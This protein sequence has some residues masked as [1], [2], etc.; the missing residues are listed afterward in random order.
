MEF[1][2]FTLVP[3]TV[4]F[5]N[6]DEMK[7]EWTNW[8]TTAE[9]VLN[10]TLSTANAIQ[11]KR[12]K[13]AIHLNTPAFY[14]KVDNRSG[15][16]LSGYMVDVH[17][18]LMKKGG[19]T[20]EYILVPNIPNGESWTTRLLEIL[21]YVDLYANNWYSDTM[22]RR[23][24]GIALTQPIV[25]ASL[26]LITVTEVGIIK[27]MPDGFLG[28][29]SHEVWLLLLALMIYHSCLYHVFHLDDSVHKAQFPYW[30][31]LY[32]SFTLF[33]NFFQNLPPNNI[34]AM[35][36]NSAYMLVL[37]VLLACYTANLA[38]VMISPVLSSPWLLDMD[39]AVSK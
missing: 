15:L 16:P 26:Q 39:D 6:P 21:P 33:T 20:F 30:R 12:I 36:L 14:M 37:M 2:K 11:G 34:S 18:A 9:K 5:Y 23:M 17:N 13:V 27:F 35:I 1:L 24:V 19:F 8:C 28:P 38:T 10:G 22:E 32:R 7:P 25:D 31:T 3:V 4:V 29:F